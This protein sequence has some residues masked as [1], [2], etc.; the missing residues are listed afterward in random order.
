[1]NRDGPTPSHGWSAAT[2]AVVHSV[3]EERGV[4]PTELTPLATV[5]DPKALDALFGSDAWLDAVE[6]TYAGY[7]V[8]LTGDGRVELSDPGD[9]N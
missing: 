3:A 5:A 2:E 9:Y 7:E 8:R 6:F 1:M 4:E